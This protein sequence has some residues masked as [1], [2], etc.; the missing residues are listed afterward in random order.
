M[1][2]PKITA[3]PSDLEFVYNGSVRLVELKDILSGSYPTDVNIK[4]S[5]TDGS[6]A[7]PLNAGTYLVTVTRTGDENWRSFEATKK[8]VIK[9]AKVVEVV[10]PTASTIT[11]GQSLSESLLS[12]GVAKGADELPYPVNL[13]G[14]MRQLY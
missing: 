7:T 4:Y 14:L 2:K 8:L 11:E 1:D 13:N 3:N 9:K 10:A 6:V 12:G 5:N